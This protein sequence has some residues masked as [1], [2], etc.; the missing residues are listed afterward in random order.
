[1]LKKKK[2][3]TKKGKW[4]AEYNVKV[5]VN[6]VKRKK[7]GA[8]GTETAGDAGCP[9]CKKKIKTTKA[10]AISKFTK[11]PYHRSC[12]KQEYRDWQTGK[13]KRLP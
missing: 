6:P 1:M 7:K 8:W 13:R 12:L 2:C 4:S 10:V 9:S 11:K 5:S 3:A